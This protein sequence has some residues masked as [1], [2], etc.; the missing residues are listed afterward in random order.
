M[1][2]AAGVHAATQSVSAATITTGAIATTTGSGVIALVGFTNSQTFV[3]LTDSVGNTAP[4]QIGSEL[5]DT[6][7]LL[8]RLYYFPNITG[9]AAHTFTLTI[10]GAATCSLLVVECTASNANGILLDQ[11]N[12]GTD[13]TSS[14][15]SPSI[16]TTVADEFLFGGSLDRSVNFSNTIIHTVGNSFTLTDEITNAGFYWTG[17]ASSRVVSATGTYNT[18]WTNSGT[19]TVSISSNWIASFSEV[20]GGAPLPGKAFQLVTSGLRW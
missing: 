9:N 16:T 8:S 6:G 4:T 12:S 20:G 19:D 14:Y 3:S 18:S 11:S 2:L 17:Y 10:S 7:T 1:A 13:A 15:D 5:Y